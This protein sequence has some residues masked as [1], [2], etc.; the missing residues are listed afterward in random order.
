MLLYIGLREISYSRTNITKGLLNLD[1][2][3]W[4]WVKLAPSSIGVSFST[5]LFGIALAY[6]HYMTYRLFV[7]LILINP[8]FVLVS[9]CFKKVLGINSFYHEYS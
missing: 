6:S 1:Q 9:L 2:F 8:V 4:L 7:A 5:T 3:R